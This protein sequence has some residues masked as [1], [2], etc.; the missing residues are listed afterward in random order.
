MSEKDLPPVP[1]A[2]RTKKGPGAEHVEHSSDLRSDAAEPRRR[3]IKP[4]RPTVP[5]A[6]PAAAG[7]MRRNRR[8]YAPGRGQGSRPILATAGFPVAAENGTAI[9]LTTRL[10]KVRGRRASR[11]AD[12]RSCA[13]AERSVWSNE[14]RR[15]SANPA[16]PFRSQGL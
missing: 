1:P 12:T 7:K 3:N 10:K 14:K 8:L 2:G 16:L 13:A 5:M 11:T 4:R 9:K 15:V 6:A